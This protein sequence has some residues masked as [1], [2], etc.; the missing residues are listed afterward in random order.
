M[1]IS[2]ER[3][4]KQIG[5]NH[6]SDIDFQDFMYLQKKCTAKPYSILVFDTTLAS[7]NPLLFN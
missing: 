7:D 6:L 3:E 2:N 1:K 4:L 5:F